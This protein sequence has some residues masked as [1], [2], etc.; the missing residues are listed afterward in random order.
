VIFQSLD[1]TP[2]EQI[3]ALAGGMV[4]AESLMALKDLMNRLGSE[5]LCTEEIF[6][7][8]LGYFHFCSPLKAGFRP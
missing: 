6:P 7:E 8:V 2:S 5:T 1:S 3:A 4:D